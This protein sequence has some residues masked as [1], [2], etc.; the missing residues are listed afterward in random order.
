MSATLI[1]VL[2]R[3]P[4]ASGTAGLCR[5]CHEAIPELEAYWGETR[6]RLTG[7]GVP[8]ALRAELWQR[9]RFIVNDGPHAGLRGRALWV[10]VATPIARESRDHVTGAKAQ[11]WEYLTHL[12]NAGGA[13][14]GVA[15]SLVELAGG[16]DAFRPYVVHEPVDVWLRQRTA[17]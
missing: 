15:C 12:V 11:E 5:Q 3:V 17:A 13:P 4:L 9:A 7:R 1:C 2:C 16:L 10:R 14:V 6:A 8:P